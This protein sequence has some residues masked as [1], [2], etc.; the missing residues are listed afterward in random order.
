[1]KTK[2]MLRDKFDIIIFNLRLLLIKEYYFLG[3]ITSSDVVSIMEEEESEDVYKR[4]GLST[5]EHSYLQHLR[6]SL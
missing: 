2:K 4:F 6:G 3:T 5:V 1:M